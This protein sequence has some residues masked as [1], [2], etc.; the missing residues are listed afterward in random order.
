MNASFGAFKLVNTYGA[1]GSVGE[2]RYEP[3]VSLSHDGRTWHE[4]RR[5]PPSPLPPAPPPHLALSRRSSS[6]ASPAR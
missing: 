5:P 1:F 6:P 3:I 4:A 2:A